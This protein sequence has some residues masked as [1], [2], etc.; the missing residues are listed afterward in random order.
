MN[1][2]HMTISSCLTLSAVHLIVFIGHRK[3]FPSTAR[4]LFTL[5]NTSDHDIML[6]PLDVE[7]IRDI[8]SYME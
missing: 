4:N 5:L 7:L 1:D 3:K 8:C 6:E 2:E